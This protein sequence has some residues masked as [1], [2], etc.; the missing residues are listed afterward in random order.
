MSN[1]V[2]E[3]F[4]GQKYWDIEMKISAPSLRSQPDLASGRKW[5][6]A[7]LTLIDNLVEAATAGDASARQYLETQL[8]YCQQTK[9][10]SPFVSTS[11]QYSVAQG[12]ATYGDTPGYVIVTRVAKRD[13][14]DFEDFR[15]RFNMFGDTTA[16]L[17]EF[18]VR[19]RLKSAWI[20]HV[21]EVQPRG[22]FTRV[23]YP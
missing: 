2:I 7:L 6:D 3:V 15:R 9:Y 8:I 12:F 18:G 4:R 13:G 5:T 21:D 23:V 1:D 14:L 17:L 20:D 22:G 10:Q 19:R 11:H 16:Y